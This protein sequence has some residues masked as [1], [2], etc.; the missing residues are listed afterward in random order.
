MTGG[1]HQKCTGYFAIN[2]DGSESGQ[3]NEDDLIEDIAN[4]FSAVGKT[5]PPLGK[6]VANIINN[7]LFN[8]VSRKK[9]EKTSFES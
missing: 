4:E 9:L 3:S 6:N 1:H 5:G 2:N 7:V 8:S